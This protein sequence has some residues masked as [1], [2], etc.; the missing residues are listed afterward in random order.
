MEIP[1]NIWFKILE[2]MASGTWDIAK[3]SRMY[4]IPEAAIRAKLVETAAATTGRQVVSGLAQNA[5][6]HVVAGEAAAQMAAATGG[7]VVADVGAGAAG[8]ATVVGTGGTAATGSALVTLGWTLAAFVVVVGVL[9]GVNRYMHRNDPPNT[10]AVTTPP[11]AATAVLPPG[12]SNAP[13]AP[14]PQ[15]CTKSQ[16]FA[17]IMRKG[18]A[19]S[20]EETRLT[21]NDPETGVT[22]TIE[23]D[24]PPGTIRV[25]DTV[26]LNSRASH[27][28]NGKPMEVQW[29]FGEG[30][31]YLFGY[32][33]STKTDT[34]QLRR[35]ADQGR[36]ETPL[37]YAGGPI[38]L[39]GGVNGA[40]EAFSFAMQWD[41]ACQ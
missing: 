4:G 24:V 2:M 41:Y 26:T 14:P 3:A 20:V 31:G 6:R 32:G 36:T 17:T 34:D 35:E 13:N 10:V 18:D 5:L 37:K 28:P 15:N 22:N 25:G 1:P 29:E 21:F 33:A 16:P 23:W 9:Y 8:G 40:G 7:V 11:A 39:K 12:L 27:F 30:R 19:I 38:R